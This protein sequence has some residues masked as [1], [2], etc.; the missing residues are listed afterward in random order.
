M[1]VGLDIGDRS[2][3]S[4]GFGGRRDQ[5]PRGDDVRQVATQR[6]LADRANL[7]LCA[8]Q[9]E[10]IDKSDNVLVMRRLGEVGPLRSSEGLLA[11]EALQAVSALGGNRVEIFLVLQRGRGRDKDR[12]RQGN[13]DVSHQ[14]LAS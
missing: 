13:R 4:P 12:K 6:C 14:K 2:A 1:N 11:G 10:G 3:Q 9:L 8:E 7:Y 5:G